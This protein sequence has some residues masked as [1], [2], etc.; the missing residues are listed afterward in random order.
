MIDECNVPFGALAARRNTMSF[1]HSARSARYA[2]G[3]AALL[4]SLVQACGE[5]VP[6]AA[7][8]TC[9]SEP[10]DDAS[11]GD[12]SSREPLSAHDAATAADGSSRLGDGEPTDD[13]PGDIAEVGSDDAARDRAAELDATSDGVWDADQAE[14]ETPTRDAGDTADALASDC[15]SADAAPD[16]AADTPADTPIDGST[17]DIS[18]GQSPLDQ[19]CL[20]DE[21]YGVFVAPTGSDATGRGTRAAPFR[22]IARGLQVAALGPK[23]LFVCDDGA[24][25]AENVVVEPVYDGLAMFGGFDCSRWIMSRYARTHVTPESGAALRISRLTAGFVVENFDL[26]SADGSQGSNS[27]AAKIDNST[28]VVLR[29]SRIAAGRGGAGADGLDGAAGESAIAPALSQSG[30]APVCRPDL[31]SQPGARTVP[32]SCGAMGGTGGL[33][34]LSVH[35]AG[36]NAG[37]NGQPTTWVSP[38]NRRNEGTTCQGDT[39]AGGAADG[40][41]GADGMSGIAGGRM[42]PG[43]GYTADGFTGYAGVAGT[44]GYPGQ[45]GGGGVGCP[46]TVGCVGPSGGAGGA[47]GCGGLRGT[48]GTA[49]GASIGLY[50]WRSA[51]H[52]DQCEVSASDGGSGGKGG[53]GGLGGK[54]NAGGKGNVGHDGSSPSGAGGMGGT[55]GS[56]AAGSGG[57]G[58]PSYGIFYAGDR[59][60]TT[61]GTAIAHGLGGAAGA[62][63]ITPAS[64]LTSSSRAADGFPGIASYEGTI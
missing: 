11:D 34:T 7:T 48:G 62:G 41:P 2:L 24:G 6:C 35:P 32:S 53:D 31:T 40:A 1:G 52:L 44:D 29:R 19:P 43:G 17:C 37:T 59:P 18:A 51:I 5:D 56:G 8:A 26:R 9:R 16:G 60:T 54:G 3:L 22:S 20:V 42:P 47:G 36:S 30:S 21:L 58:G 49:G 13:G 55:G 4:T 63:G 12:A 23:R 28:G 46:A 15:A 50:S 33:G 10:G 64:P 61:T 27:I 57:N 14:A 25:Y 45:G 38:A 39:A